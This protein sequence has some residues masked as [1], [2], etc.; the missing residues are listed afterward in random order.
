M[1]KNAAL[2]PSPAKDE[3]TTSTLNFFSWAKKS[4]RD[5]LISS[6]VKNAP[7]A[8]NGSGG[9]FKFMKRARQGCQPPRTD[10]VTGTGRHY[11]SAGKD[12][13][14]ALANYEWRKVARTPPTSW[15]SHYGIAERQWRRGWVF[16][17]YKFVW[18]LWIGV[19][20]LWFVVLSCLGVFFF[21]FGKNMLGQLLK[22]L[23]LNDTSTHW[24]CN[25][26]LVIQQIVNML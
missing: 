9:K 8:K 16:F 3:P 17:F 20:W 10:S 15:Y 25:L 7:L 13:R 5:P 23:M 19:L 14:P 21:L 1:S 12:C 6:L 2:K 4:E 11:D 18:F 26:F 24:K 22:W